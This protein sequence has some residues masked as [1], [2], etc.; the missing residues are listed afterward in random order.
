[1]RLIG[2]GLL[3]YLLVGLALLFSKFSIFENPRN[4][5]PGL[6]DSPQL[7]FETVEAQRPEEDTQF[8]VNRVGLYEPMILSG[9]PAYQRAEY[10][11][12]LDARPTSGFLQINVTFQVSTGVEGVLRVSI[13]NSKRGEILLPAGQVK[14]S[15]K[16]PLAPRELIREKLVVSFSMLGTGA[17]A[18]CSVDDGVEAIAEIETTS[19]IILNTQTPI[20][21][22]SD[23]FNQWGRLARVSWQRSL[24]HKNALARLVA[25]TKFRQK[26][27]N[28]VLES[29]NAQTLFKTDDLREAAIK[30]ATA[31]DSTLQVEASSQSNLLAQ[32]NNQGVRR[33]YRQSA[34]RHTYDFGE[35]GNWNLLDK[36]NIALR[37]GKQIGDEFW[38]VSMTLN[39]HLVMEEHF[40]S[41]GKKFS[42]TVKLPLEYQQMHNALEI[43]VSSSS[44]HDGECNQGPKLL[45]ELLADTKLVE[46][47]EVYNNP[48]LNLTAA[49][50]DLPSIKVGMSAQLNAVEATSASDILANLLPEEK[51][52]VP[53]LD[54]PHILV[55]RPGQQIDI[56]LRDKN[57]IVYRDIETQQVVVEL[58]EE[59]SGKHKNGLYIIA[60]LN[61]LF[62]IGARL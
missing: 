19:T 23:K 34:W 11:L 24:T 51:R 62:Q 47:D 45:A 55:V 2:I 28:V 12:P 43:T 58:V 57:Y 25:V 54:N 31:T 22:V 9:L 10:F 40:Q 52:L 44:D 14:K 18:A 4:L 16:I 41:N 3:S 50:Q 7:V 26:G 27:L 36:I 61:P 48:V 59:A 20:Q 1:M 42:K 38:I 8:E 21:S 17:N 15:L 33:F 30:L 39:K 37:L 53:V 56:E 49:L 32:K 29:E 35:N 5:I 6:F 60:D 46:S 13:D